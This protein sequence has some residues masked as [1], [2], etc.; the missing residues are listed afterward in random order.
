MCSR[1]RW[2]LQLVT[3]GFSV[4]SVEKLQL[5]EKYALLR[6]NYYFS[7]HLLLLTN[8]LASIILINTLGSVIQALTNSSQCEDLH[9]LPNCFPGTIW[10]AGF[11]FQWHKSFKIRLSAGLLFP[12]QLLGSV[13]MVRRSSSEDDHWSKW[14]KP[15][16]RQPCCQKLD[17]WISR[18]PTSPIR[19]PDYRMYFLRIGKW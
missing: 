1:I 9:G 6:D 17:S 10:D 4:K 18:R 3:V 5:L 19:L 16:W 7:L 2:E 13:I 12:A 15:F 8:N 14:R 11:A